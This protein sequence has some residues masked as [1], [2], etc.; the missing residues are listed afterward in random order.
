MIVLSYDIVRPYLRDINTTS[1][2]VILFDTAT[3]YQNCYTS[4]NIFIHIHL[5]NNNN[6]NNKVNKINK[7]RIK[8]NNNDIIDIDYGSMQL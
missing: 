5:D 3:L 6:N 2:D 8:I 4:V 1:F 7:T